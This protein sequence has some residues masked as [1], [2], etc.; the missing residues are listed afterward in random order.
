MEAEHHNLQSMAAIGA[1]E[2]AGLDEVIGVTGR[3]I[4]PTVGQA[5]AVGGTARGSAWPEQASS[6]PGGGTGL[7]PSSHSQ[8]AGTAHLAPFAECFQQD[9][10][11]APL[12]LH[13]PQERSSNHCEGNRLWDPSR[14]LKTG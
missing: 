4:D 3:E 8:P 1:L 6:R 12:L 5:V 14:G 11:E 13:Y 2:E 10:K 9:R 7:N